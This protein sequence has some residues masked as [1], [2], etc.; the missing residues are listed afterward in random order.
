MLI[1]IFDSGRGGYFVAER[2]QE[3][4][5]EHDF[6]VADDSANVPYGTRTKEEILELTGRAIQPLLARCS[7]IVIAC[8]TITTAIIHLLRERYPDVTFVG[9]EPMVK[10]ASLLTRSGHI[11]VLATPSTLSSSRYQ[12]LKQAHA[13][14][15]TIDEPPTAHWPRS[16]EDDEIEGLD[17]GD[18]ISSHDDGADVIVLGCTHYLALIPRL[19]TIL[20]DVTILE[21]SEAIARRV[22]QVLAQPNSSIDQYD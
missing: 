6:I 3:I 21:P 19:K 16:I 14:H 10:P 4:L 13:S 7:I 17:L 9:L 8:N 11:A 22:R 15:L 12:E 18:V 20:S 1:G 2:L 5:P